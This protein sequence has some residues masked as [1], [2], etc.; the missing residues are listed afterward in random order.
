MSSAKVDISGW[1]KQGFNLYKDNFLIV[2][3]CGIIT[4]V[5]GSIS[6]GILAGPLVVG[7]FNI[8]LR[9]HRKSEPKPEIQD[10]FK[11][12]E[13]FLPSFLFV[14]VWGVVNLI[15]QG[16]L[17]MFPLGNFLGSCFGLFLGSLLLFGI[18]L[19]ADQKLDFWPASQKSLNTIKPKLVEYLIFSVALSFLAGIGVLLLGIGIFFT[20]P[21]YPCA[22]A[23]AYNSV[24]PVSKKAS[25]TPPQSPPQSPPQ[26]P[27]TPPPAEEKSKAQGGGSE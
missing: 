8:A 14:L 19:I 22:V 26:T 27:P 5:L 17:A 7:F 15:G 21:L 11:G 16:I 25:A 20:I 13:L 24:F 3:V 9:L 12:F 1:I 6:I 18:P 4:V 23:V 10:I 2:F